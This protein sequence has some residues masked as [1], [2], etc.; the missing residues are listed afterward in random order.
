[1]R[2]GGGLLFASVHCTDSVDVRHAIGHLRQ[3][4]GRIE[5]TER[6]LRDEQRLS[7]DRRRVLHLLKALGRRGA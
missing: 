3:E 7:D 6:L 1:M 2:S 4:L 5:P